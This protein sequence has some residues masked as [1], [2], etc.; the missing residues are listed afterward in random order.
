MSEPTGSSTTAAHNA[1][2]MRTYLERV[3]R[4]GD[5]GLIDQL[6]HADVVDEANAAFG[7]PPGRA[8]LVAHVR[9]FRKHIPDAELDIERIVA[10]DTCAIAWWRFRGTHVGPWLGVPPTSGPVTGTVISLFEMRD[11]RIARYRLTLTADVD[12]LRVFDTSQTT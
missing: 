4:D 1:A 5:I 6:A 2:V 9:G 7:G 12:G 8:G 11:G 3:A 10:D